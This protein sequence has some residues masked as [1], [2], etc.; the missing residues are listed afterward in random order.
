MT[1]S[2]ATKRQYDSIL[3]RLTTEKMFPLLETNQEA[4][5]AWVHTRAS[6][7]GSIDTQNSYINAIL[8][9]LRLLKADVSAYERESKRLQLI[10]REK[11][12]SQTLP[13]AKMD[14]MLPWPEVLALKDKAKELNDED[15]L[16]YLFYTAIPPK[17]ADFCNLKIFPRDAKRPG[18]YIIAG[19]KYRLVLQ[20]YKTS[21][22]FGKQ[23]F[24]LPDEIKEQIQKLDAI[25]PMT[26]NNLSKRV[27]SIFKKLSGKEM[28]INLLRHSF[29]THFL[30]TKRSIKEKEAMA[31]QMLHSKDLQERYDII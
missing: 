5:V 8:N 13:Q 28:S 9:H 27:S 29:I 19:K 11:S 6:P 18:N 1:L 21:K 24:P 3:N 23:V 15:Y 17:R 10:R 7:S 31:L 12:K 4:V 26:E 2:P 30:Q 22:T 16:I 25:L 20:D 14:E